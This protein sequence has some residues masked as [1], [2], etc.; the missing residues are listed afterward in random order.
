M[1]FFDLIGFSPTT[2]APT[3]TPVAPP[4]VPTVPSAIDTSI[5]GLQGIQNQ[6]VGGVTFA[7][8]GLGGSAANIMGPQSVQTPVQTQSIGS[9]AANPIQ[10][11]NSMLSNLIDAGSLASSIY[12][13]YKNREFKKAQVNHNIDKDKN[14]QARTKNLKRSLTGGSGELVGQKDY[15]NI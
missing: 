2:V 11:S 5:A 15:Q 6:G 14:S 12:A 3:V 13:D 7:D 8:S 4:V 10:Q 9:A 1:G